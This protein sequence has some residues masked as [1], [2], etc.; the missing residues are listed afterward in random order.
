MSFAMPFIIRSAARPFAR[1][2]LM[3][4]LSKVILLSRSHRCQY[5]MLS[6]GDT[7]RGER[8]LTYRLVRPLGSDSRSNVWHAVDASRETSQY[9]AKGPSDGDD[10]SREWPAFQHELDMQRLFVN[11]PMIRELVDFVPSSES[12]GPLMI[13]EPMPMTLWE[14]RNTRRLTKREIK[15]IM[16]GILLGIGA[17]HAK[18]MVFSD[19]KMENVGVGGFDAANPNPNVH[20]IIVRLMDLGSISL[21]SDKE[22]TSLT[23]RSPEVH[24]GKP[25][26]QSADI[27]SWGVILAQL[28]QAAVDFESPGLYDNVTKGT[29]EEKTRAV[30]D[31]LAVDF[32]LHSV[33]FYARDERC[34]ALLPPPRPDEA[35]M[36][37]NSMVEKGV[38]G[39]DIQF[40]V[41]VLHPDPACRLSVREILESGYFEV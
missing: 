36:W 41:E 37:A 7:F 20:E 34:R 14:A 26:D 23:Y 29:L 1:Y 39:E 38:S 32:D 5:S 9:I 27:W 17:V 30:R 28:L 16:R 25:W 33:P 21:P 8:G 15:W 12:A 4:G 19:L 2:L 10:K 35:Y 3:A 13:L 18:R 11:A 22:I 40:L 24:F 31:G 6:A